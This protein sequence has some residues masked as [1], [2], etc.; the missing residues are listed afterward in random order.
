MKPLDHL[1][2]RPP[3]PPVH[4]RQRILALDGAPGVGLDG[5]DAP[6]SWIDRWWQSRRWWITWAAVTAALLVLD[7]ALTDPLPAPSSWGRVSLVELAR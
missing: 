4:L 1:P 2:I 6:R 7:V 5:S 3:A